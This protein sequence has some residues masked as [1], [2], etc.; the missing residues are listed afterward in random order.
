VAQKVLITAGGSGIGLAIAGEFLADGADVF[1]CDVS[2]SAL[3]SAFSDNPKLKG[4]LADVGNP[5]EVEKMF[6]QV[7]EELGG[8]DVLI[9]NAGIGGQR[10]L[11]E[12]LDYKEWDDTI[13]I[14]LSGMF[15]CI[16]NAIPIMKKQRSGSVINISTA[17]VKVGLPNRLPYVT[18]KA[19]VHGLSHTLA[20]E[21]GPFNIRSNIILPGFID[22]QRGIDIATAYAKDRGVSLEE[23]E[24]EFLEMI[25]MR[26]KIK[27]SE[28]GEMAV[29]LASDKAK[30]ITA[31]EI[32]VDGNLEWEG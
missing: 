31:Q 6:Q 23:V 2:E 21:V 18:S 1:I 5:S 14:N 29:F 30:H 8:L 3:K 7:L 22:N 20:R 28:I 26:I 11:V 32:A 27:M 24:A 4:C 10:G 9:N 12:D 15:Y 19:G 16:K 17:S 13:R 25:S